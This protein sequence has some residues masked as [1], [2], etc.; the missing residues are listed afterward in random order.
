MPP[1]TP[2][3]IV[4]F[5]ANTLPGY[6]QQEDTPFGVRGLFADSVNRHGG[7]LDTGG[8]ALR[9]IHLDMRV[10]SRLSSGNGLAHLN[11]CKAQIREALRHV[12]RVSGPARLEIGDTDRYLNAIFQNSSFTLLAGETKR[13]SYS[14]DF[15]AEPFFISDTPLA[16]TIAGNGSLDVTFTD[17]TAQT[18]PTFSLPSTLTG[19]TFT[20][21][22]K[23][24]TFLRGSV[25]GAIT[26]DCA[27]LTAI[28]DSDGTNVVSTISEV[29]WGFSHTSTG[30]FTVT[31]TG[32]AGSGTIT[33]NIAARFER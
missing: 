32:Y 6:L 21:G 27:R 30:T 22:T 9:P 28:K 4:T 33:M 24:L 23:V 16:D 18:Y 26:I 17:N 25:T 10:L 7:I 1:P 31:V 8:A 14:L 19:V 5:N 13:I 29:D 3:Y 12:A 2:I 20:V 15:M 11:D